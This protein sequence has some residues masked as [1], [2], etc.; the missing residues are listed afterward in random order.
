MAMACAAG[1]G[2]SSLC[3]LSCSN[4]HP[5]AVHS[6]Q[7]DVFGFSIDTRVLQFRSLC[8]EKMS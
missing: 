5:P 2:D 4:H 1:R 8:K 7:G 6:K 3:S